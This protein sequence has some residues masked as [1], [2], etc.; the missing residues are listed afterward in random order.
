MWRILKL[1]TC[2]TNV[3]MVQV[4]VVAGGGV[5]VDVLNDVIVGGSGGLE[6]DGGGLQVDVVADAGVVGGV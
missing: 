6:M 1:E 5:G 2:L 3:V 4:E